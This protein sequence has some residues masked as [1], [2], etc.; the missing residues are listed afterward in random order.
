[1]QIHM[2][3]EIV[4]EY[5]M[6]LDYSWHP[7]APLEGPVPLAASEHAVVSA[8]SPDLRLV[9]AVVG[10][11]VHQGVVLGPRLLDGAQ[12]PPHTRIQLRHDISIS[13][14]LT[15]SPEPLICVQRGVHVGKA[16]IQQKG[17]GVSLLLLY[18]V[19]R[20]LDQLVGEARQLDW[21]LDD[22]IILYKF[23]L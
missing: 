7:H 6:D 11:E 16:V 17:P 19:N 4:I 13:A 8:L 22:V 18:E 23:K 1:M 20:F 10:G 15:D 12:N 5:K 3:L 21:F 9:A 14:V 2:G